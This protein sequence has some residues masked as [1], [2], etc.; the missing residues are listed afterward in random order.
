MKHDTDTDTSRGIPRQTRTGRAHGSQ[1]GHKQ[2]E[3]VAA[4]VS[5]RNVE[6]AARVTNLSPQTLYRWKKIPEFET[7]YHEAL[8][9]IYRQ[10]LAR[11]RQA[12]GVAVAVLLKE[13]LDSAAPKSARLKAADLVLRHSKSAR[14]IRDF[15]VRLR[16]VQRARERFR[17]CRFGKGAGGVPADEKQS[18]SKAGPGAKLGRRKQEAIVA[19]LTQVNVQEAARLAGI[20]ATT[21]YRWLKDPAF[22]AA[23]QEAILAAFGQAATRL[24]QAGGNDNPADHGRSGCI[25]S[26]ACAGCEPRSG[27]RNDGERGRCREAHGEVEARPARC[28]RCVVGQQRKRRGKCAGAA[29]G[30]MRQ[31]LYRELEEWE[32]IEA[33]ALQARSCRNEPSGVE[34]LGQLLGRYAV[35]RLA[36]ES[37]A[38]TVARTAA[39]SAQELKDLLWEGAQANAEN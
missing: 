1:F 30:G 35:A 20:G 37:L 12:A 4:L 16:A 13:M 9:A 17:P 32:R 18:S 8:W 7:A 27:A 3:A 24:D 38:E 29:P 19:L 11:T 6:E 34:V 23:Y 36:H 15:D 22:D 28:P 5:Q 33:A 39:I 25:G 31:R 2:E 14:R 21:L 26:S 10:A